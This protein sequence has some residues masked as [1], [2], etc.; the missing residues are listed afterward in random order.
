MSSDARA[1]K[2]ENKWDRTASYTYKGQERAGPLVPQP[3]VH[4]SR[5]EDAGSTPERSQKCLRSQCRSCLVLVG[6]DKIVISRVV[7][8]NE[9]ESNSKTSEGW[10][11]YC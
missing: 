2:V 3:I 8:E 5:E 11:T 7:E 10:T 9:A 1:E 6:I 4:L